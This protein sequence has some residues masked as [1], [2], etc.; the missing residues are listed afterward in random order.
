MKLKNANTVRAKYLKMFFDF[1]KEQSED[2]GIIASNSLNFPIV[3]DSEEGWVEL[4][5]KVPK[6]DE[7]YEKRQE[8]E[9]KET[10]KAEKKKEQA[11][12]KAKKIERDK[13]LREQKKK[14][15]ENA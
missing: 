14:E 9:I 13:K 5:V 15:K 4:V 8:Y 6:E 1:L 11:K 7:G 3:E 12:A 2:V 10:T